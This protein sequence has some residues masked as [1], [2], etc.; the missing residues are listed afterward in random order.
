ME[1]ASW[2]QVRQLA[3][4]VEQLWQVVD[5]PEVT[6]TVPS[7]HVLEHFESVV[8]GSVNLTKPVPQVS[9]EREVVLGQAMHPLT[10]QAM[11]QVV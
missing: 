2:E 6:P 1:L 3:M 9:Q 8:P 11:L 4:V 7:G 10:T 5:P